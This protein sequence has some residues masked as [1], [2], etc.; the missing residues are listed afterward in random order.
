MSWPP[1]VPDINLKKPSEL[2][3]LEKLDPKSRE[4]MTKQEISDHIETVALRFAETY[5]QKKGSTYDECCE[6]VSLALNLSGGALNG[7]VGLEMMGTSSGAAE[8]ACRI[9][10]DNPIETN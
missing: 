6:M 3:Y 2:E 1:D 10:F 8:N 7:K 9:A 4:A 5:K